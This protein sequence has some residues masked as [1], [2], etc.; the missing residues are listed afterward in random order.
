MS[1]GR[2]P[3]QFGQIFFGRGDHLRWHARESRDLQA[4]TLIRRAVLH[5]VQEDELLAVFG[6]VQMHVGAGIE[7][8]GERSQLEVVGGKQREG[9]N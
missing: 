6:G 3:F 2:T 5:R 7:I 1:F 8:A 9:A 4:V